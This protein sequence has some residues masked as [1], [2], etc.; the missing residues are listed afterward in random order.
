MRRTLALVCAA[1]TSMV[2]IAFLIP[3]ALVV[4]QFA[5]DRAFGD[6]ELQAA[7]IG[8]NDQAD[9]IFTLSDAQQLVSFAAS[10]HLAWLSMWSAGRDQECSDGAQA[11][12]QPTCSSIVQAPLAFMTALG[13]Y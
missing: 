3:L 1:V 12:A 9:E 13:Q 11:S 5:R 2:A 4:R 6:A 8:V 7:A 10:K